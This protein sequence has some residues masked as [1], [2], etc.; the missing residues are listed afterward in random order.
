MKVLRA[1]IGSLVKSQP[2]KYKLVKYSKNRQLVKRVDSSK[3]SI[4]Q[5]GR[6]VNNLLVKNQVAQTAQK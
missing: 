5:K 3:P 6:F 1:G 4:G 2:V